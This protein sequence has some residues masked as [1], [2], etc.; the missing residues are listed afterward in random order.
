MKAEALILADDRLEVGFSLI[1]EHGLSIFITTEEGNFLF[2]TGQGMSLGNNGGLLGIDF[3]S[4][5]AVVLSH[6]HYDHTRGLKSLSE[7]VGGGRRLISHPDVF[8]PRY[9]RGKRRGVEVELFIGLP[10]FKDELKEWGF[11]IITTSS[12]LQLNGIVETTG[13]IPFFY[14]FERADKGF[15]I[16]RGEDL[17]P[18]EFYDDLALIVK[19]SNGVSVI[20]GCAHRGICNT[21]QHVSKLT[22]TEEFYTVMGGFHMFEADE[23]R[24]R[25]TIEVLSSF[26][27]KRLIPC[28]CTGFKA[29]CALN[30]RFG[31]S[32]IPGSVGL[33]VEL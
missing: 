12:P 31:D 14:S 1:G 20:T 13:E 7:M 28:H 4:I 16:K 3:S 32:L 10:Y 15:Y 23:E 6:G 27:I 24:I 22:N 5:S 18:D 9:F 19:T 2:D 26:K 11:E 25:N 21:L 33:K 8:L 29:M 17:L 30:V